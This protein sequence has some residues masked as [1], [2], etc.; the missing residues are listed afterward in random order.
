MT[1]K[2]MF[3]CVICLRPFSTKQVFQEHFK[4]PKRKSGQGG[5]VRNECQNSSVQE[6][7]KSKTEAETVKQQVRAGG[8]A[9]FFPVVKKPCLDEDISS[10]KSDMHETEESDSTAL[11][12]DTQRKSD[13]PELSS[14]QEQSV[15]NLYDENLGLCTKEMDA[16][17][18]ASQSDS[19]IKLDFADNEKLTKQL[20]DIKNDTVKIVEMIQKLSAPKNDDLSSYVSKKQCQIESSSLTLLTNARSVRDIMFNPLIKD[21]YDLVKMICHEDDDDNS[22]VHDFSDGHLVCQICSSKPSIYFLDH[23]YNCGYYE[24]MER[25]FINAKKS[26]KRHLESPDHIEKHQCHQK[27]KIEEGNIVEQVEKAV[28]YLVYFIIRTNSAFLSYSKLLATVFQSGLEIGN[29]NHSQIFP[30]KILRLIDAVLQENTK[31]WLDHQSKLSISLD[32][33]T[34]MGLVMLVVYYIGT[35]GSTRIAGCDLTHSKAGEHCAAKCYEIAK[36]NI[37]VEESMIRA[38]TKAIVADGAFVDGNSPFKNKIRE[39]FRNPS[40]IFRWDL[41]H[42][43]NRAHIAARGRTQVD[44]GND[45]QQASISNNQSPNSKLLSNM[46]DYI[47]SE[48]KAW[49]SGVNYTRLVIETLDFMRPKIYS[50]TR[51]CLYEFDQVKRFVEVSH[52]FDVPWEYDVLSKI[53]LLVLFVEKIILKF[54]QKTDNQRD[55]VNRVF[56]ATQPEGKV[57]MK[58]A[59][60]V[61]MNVIRKEPISYLDSGSFVDILSTDPTQ[62]KFIRDLKNLISELGQKLVPDHLSPPTPRTRRQENVSLADLE[63]AVLNFIDRIWDEFKQR[64][65]R[66]DLTST[67]SWCFSEA[68][69][70]SFFSKWGK[71]VNERPSLK[72]EN[73]LILAKI[74]L[75]GPEAGT[76]DSHELMKK[77]M[78]QYE[79]FSHFGERY[80]TQTWSAGEVSSTVRDHMNKVWKYAQFE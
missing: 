71:I 8:L 64:T 65:G 24:N 18:P 67:D 5:Y 58:L 54:A 17:I 3:W 60:K 73:V 12:D 56:L 41:L 22:N 13:P 21:S 55:Y 10:N 32:I 43:F 28:R 20:L 37:F 2:E 39:L 75:E 72:F 19:D 80:T 40:M 36:S 16:Q 31:N 35:D 46:M 47:Q 50:S 38:K 42:M 74:Q 15:S 1:E 59:L 49:R 29:I 78:V 11:H 69:C 77:A 26:L 33:G 57:A 51:M 30:S 27:K 7:A 44:I 70:E 4:T 68:P 52:Y 14:C 6:F 23:D 25:W 63:A 76:D 9:A 45:D 62:N 48:S 66:T 53:Y 79:T 61:A 34:V